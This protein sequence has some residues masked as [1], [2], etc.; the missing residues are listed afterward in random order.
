MG[1]I[2]GRWVQKWKVDSWKER[3]PD[4]A[5]TRYT[6]SVSSELKW[7]CSCPHWKFRRL[8]CKHI[9]EIKAGL[10]AENGDPA[11]TM[12]LMA[13]IIEKLKG[14]GKTDEQIAEILA[15]R[16]GSLFDFDVSAVA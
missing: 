9:A 8:E 12:R 3:E 13:I 5:P 1:Q 14:R 15:N 7:G 11:A 2:Q 16:Q 4:A 6:V 10:G